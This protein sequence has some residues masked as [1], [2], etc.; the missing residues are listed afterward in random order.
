[1][2]NDINAPNPKDDRKK[3]FYFFLNTAWSGNKKAI[4]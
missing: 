4:N 2:P 3:E 1:M